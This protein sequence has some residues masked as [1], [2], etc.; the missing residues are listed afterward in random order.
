VG[1]PAASY[2]LAIRD[3]VG[4]C[5][6]DPARLG[7]E[8]FQLLLGSASEANPSRKTI[9]WKGFRADQLCKRAA[10]DAEQRFDLE[11]TILPLTES[12]TVPGILVSFRLNVRY[13][14]AITSDQNWPGDPRSLQGPTGDREAVTK[15]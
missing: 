4:K 5:L 13:A 10:H 6:K 9:Y 11:S 8:G 2:P 7:V 12:E 15:Q 1:W 14:V 3:A